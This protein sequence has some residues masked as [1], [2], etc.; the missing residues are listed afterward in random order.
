MTLR[1]RLI[2][3]ER[4]VETR[5]AGRSIVYLSVME[6][7]ST[8]KKYKVEHAEYLKWHPNEISPPAPLANNVGVT[9]HVLRTPCYSLEC[10]WHGATN[11]LL[12]DRK[13]S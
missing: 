13:N 3:L 7:D 2:Q 8:I 6:A 10:P 12:Q 1:T 5:N 4:R 9:F 11:R